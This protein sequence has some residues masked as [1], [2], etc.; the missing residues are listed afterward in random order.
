MKK[1]ARIL[2]IAQKLLFSGKSDKDFLIPLFY[3]ISFLIN[4]ELLTKNIYAIILRICLSMILSLLIRFK[5]KRHEL[6][7]LASLYWFWEGLIFLNL[8]FFL[9]GFWSSF[10]LFP[11]VRFMTISALLFRNKSQKFKKPIFLISYMLLA[12]NMIFISLKLNFLGLP[13]LF[14]DLGIF[15]YFFSSKPPN[16][17]NSLE[18]NHVNLSEMLNFLPM[19]FII[20]NKGKKIDDYSIENFND[21]ALNLLGVERK[22]MTVP[23][24]VSEMK[25]FRLSK[26]S[27]QMRKKLTK[28]EIAVHGL[29]MNFR[30]ILKKLKICFL[31]A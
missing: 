18:K 11:L 9:C 29:F 25:T 22:Y 16:P 7:V 1:P 13:A 20:V 5:K 31:Y 8:E 2:T 19:G 14:I 4:S 30:N 12:L 6:S 10:L 27:I 24:L 15:Y 21:Q 17:E 3:M 26:N 28:I 23:F